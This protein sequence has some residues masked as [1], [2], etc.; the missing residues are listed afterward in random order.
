MQAPSRLKKEVP[1]GWV[2]LAGTATA[3][4]H[5]SLPRETPELRF[6]RIP[7]LYVDAFWLHF[8]DAEKDVFVPVRGIGLFTP[9][10]P[11]SAEDFMATSRK[12]AEERKARP[13]DDA[14]AP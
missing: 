11:V 2:F 12:A 1:R 4:R 5:A 7:A 10:Q 8:E 14:I 9:M 13:S 3:L 6:V